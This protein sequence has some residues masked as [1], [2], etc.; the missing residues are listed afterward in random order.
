[1]KKSSLA[2]AISATLAAPFAAAQE[3]Q[4]WA[5]EEVIVTSQKRM[6]TLQDIPI[7]VSAFTG[8]FIADAHI[9]DVKALTTLTP[10]VTGDSDDSF[11]DT[12][13]IR[14]VVTN[15]FGVG[16]E[17]SIG[18]YQDGVYLG[19]TGGAVTS[20][21]DLEMIEVVKGPQGTLFGRNS[22]AGAISIATKKPH[23]EVEGS[24]T[25]GAAED[26]YS[27]YTGVFN[28][29]LS[30]T[31]AMRMAY[32]HEEQDGWIKNIAGG[33]DLGFNNVDAGR[34]SFAY[35]GEALSAT[36]SFEYED[37]EANGSTY[38]VLNRD[39]DPRLT[40]WERPSK[41]YGE[42]ASD[43]GDD[44]SDEG[45]VWGATLTLEYDLSD[46]YALTSI[47][48]YRGHNYYY[49]EDF[50]GSAEAIDHYA[51]NQ[52]QEYFSQELRINYEGEGDITWFAGVSVYKERLSAQVSDSYDEDTQCSFS[53][54]AY[55][56][57]TYGLGLVDESAYTPDCSAYYFY[58]ADTYGFQTGVAGNGMVTERRAID[59]E[60]EGWGVYGDITWAATEDLEFTLGA[61]YTQDKRDLGLWMLEDTE[62]ANPSIFNGAAYTDGYVYQDDDWSN[63][64]PRLAANYYINYD[65][66]VYATIS[67]GYK[68]GGYNTN[69]LGYKDPAKNGAYYANEILNGRS[70]DATDNALIE[71]FDQ[72]EVTNYEIGV[73]S[74][75]WDNRIEAKASIFQY[76][77]DDYQVN[78]FDADIVATR[79]VNAGDAQG[80]GLEADL[81]I[82]PT[83]NIDIYL[84]VAFLDT[85]L[86]KVKT[87]AIC[88][89]C[90]D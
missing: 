84:G 79:V 47:S 72:E 32:F 68:A 6:Q 71:S 67:Q 82:L 35:M 88:T 23:E 48:A 46:E 66:S 81:R 80:R 51:Q 27:T 77:F 70:G 53:A 14:G 49:L 50:D 12:L 90:K 58:N 1:M 8:D 83:Q 13:N 17:P 33:K 18:L 28:T 9:T 75:W 65:I 11:L 86:T 61:R 89:D 15:D 19:R 21:F 20:F 22:S 73:K 78:Y 42:V 41:K 3:T 60:Y 63:F 30:D 55:A 87:A 25:I 76:D 39:T 69:S 85:E 54:T 59:A 43:L 38:N 40:G 7:A 34:L 74:K 26:G 2:L 4:S 37:H 24:L 57:A 29:P 5:I 44:S 52:E 45:E 31:F 62:L 56:A 36:L 64:S 10:G 16:A